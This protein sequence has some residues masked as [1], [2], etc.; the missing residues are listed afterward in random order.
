MKKFEKVIFVIYLMLF[1]LFI[2]LKFDGS[3][4][5]LYNIR[6][7]IME[8]KK[9]GL[10]NISLI[11]L[12][13]IKNYLKVLPEFYAIKNLLGNIIPFIPFGYFI[14]IYIYKYKKSFFCVIFSFILLCITI[15]TIQ[16][17]FSI[18]FFDIDD[19]ILNLIGLILGYLIFKIIKK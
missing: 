5:Y 6:Y 7:S 17:I 2:M 11:P 19:I 1:I 9:Y 4:H 18:G 14:P 8:N 12:K 13:T 10:A 3:F 15:E 16:Y